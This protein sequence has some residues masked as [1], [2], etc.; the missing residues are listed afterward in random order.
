M[1]LVC[2]E[3]IEETNTYSTQNRYLGEERI[4]NFSSK[5]GPKHRGPEFAL[6]VVDW[7]C[8]SNYKH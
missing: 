5:L 3:D 1:N 4:T 6:D 2:L 8:L 7:R